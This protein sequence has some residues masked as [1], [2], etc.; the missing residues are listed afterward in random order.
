MFCTSDVKFVLKYSIHFDAIV[1]RFSLISFSDYS[2]IV[3]TQWFLF[4]D[5]ISYDLALILCVCF[6]GFFY[7]QN[8]ASCE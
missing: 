3:Q 1:T 7:M 5:L 8:H 2:L 4:I 6:L